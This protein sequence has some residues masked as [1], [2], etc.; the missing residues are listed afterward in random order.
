[1][2][3][4][5]FVAA[6]GKPIVLKRRLDHSKSQLADKENLE[7]I[8]ATISHKYATSTGSRPQVRD[9][10]FLLPRSLFALLKVALPFAVFV[11]A[12]GSY[13]SKIFP[14]PK[15]AQAVSN[16]V[17]GFG[18]GRRATHRCSAYP[19][20]AGIVSKTRSRN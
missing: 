5:G 18:I 19:S 12:T 7:K 6:R 11:T 17:S 20:G 14:S 1:M 13:T 15:A 9:F 3:K 2:G 16:H 8:A 4:Y 10:P